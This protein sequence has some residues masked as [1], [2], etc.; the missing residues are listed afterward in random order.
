MGA[1]DTI[2]AWTSGLIASHVRV[3]PSPK[4]TS[5]P[6]SNLQLAGATR[7]PLNQTEAPQIGLVPPAADQ[8]ISQGTEWKGV[9][10]MMVVNNDSPPV[11]V[12]IHSA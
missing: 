12:T 1:C 8:D 2:Y 3:K 4:S 6:P 11:H 7:A 5:G 9:A 10:A